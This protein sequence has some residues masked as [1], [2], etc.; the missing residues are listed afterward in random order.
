[1]TQIQ[2]PNPFNYGVDVDNIVHKMT[3]STSVL[4]LI[5]YYNLMQANRYDIG[6]KVRQRQ[7]KTTFM[8]NN[9][10]MIMVCPD[11]EMISI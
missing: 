8:R 9:V 2:H 11:G 10:S 6:I 1:M 7:D 3:I 4:L 5:T